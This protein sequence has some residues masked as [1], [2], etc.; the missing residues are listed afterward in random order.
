MFQLALLFHIPLQTKYYAISCPNL[1]QKI[2]ELTL[3]IFLLLLYSHLV[4]SP[5]KTRLTNIPFYSLNYLFL[6]MIKIIVD[7]C[8]MF[9]GVLF[10]M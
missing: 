6:I 4:L 1:L 9:L 10:T 5:T 2:L 3:M 7:L 8:V